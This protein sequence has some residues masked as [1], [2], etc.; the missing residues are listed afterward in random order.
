[1][2][3]KELDS[4]LSRRQDFLSLL[5]THGNGVSRL[6]SFVNPF[7]FPLVLKKEI[8][9]DVDFWFADGSLLCFLSN[10]FRARRDQID[11][12]S[13]DFT[14]IANDVFLHC[15][16]KKFRLAIIGGTEDEAH[17]AVGYLNTVYPKIN[18]TFIR[19]G[20]NIASNKEKIFDDIDKSNCD[21][22]I[23]GLGT[24]L[25][26][27]FGIEVK[28]ECKCKLVFT[29]GGFISQTSS[30]GDYYHPFVKRLGLRWL[31]RAI[32]HDHVRSRLLI[33]YPKFIL[34]Y[35]SSQLKSKVRG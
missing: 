10:L 13:F 6:I 1:M 14:S 19:G 28:N 32:L 31:Q 24:P 5:K 18:I 7:S 4:K 27:T 23:L 22:V 9:S 3:Y 12:V 25:Q 17:R 26:E 11:R 8:I 2:L 21:V 35:I 20:F 34:K 33:S 15:V 29:C 30:H 16:E